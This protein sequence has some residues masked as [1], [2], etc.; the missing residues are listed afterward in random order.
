MVLATTMTLD[1]FLE[2]PETEPPSE[3][4]C[5]RIVPKP[6][7]SWFHSRLAARL[8]ALFEIY[9]MNHDEGFANVE[10]RHTSRSEERAYLPD[11]S[12]TRWANAPKSL[13][14][15]RRGPIERVPDIAIEI[16]S[17]DDR[18]GRIADKLAFYLRAGVPLVWIVDPDE[19]TVSAYRPGAQVEM[20]GTGDTLTGS[21]VFPGFSLSIADLFGVL[22]QHLDE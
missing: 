12:V 7:P 4:V 22:D 21:P 20:F 2:L 1:E 5:G 8:A 16:T 17:T 18:A 9:F 19:R 6:M 13:G 3:F 14:D 15:R 11:V 10:L